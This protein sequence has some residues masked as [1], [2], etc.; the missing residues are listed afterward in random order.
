MK[1]IGFEL[2]DWERALFNKLIGELDL[3]LIGET[4]N[5]RIPRGILGCQCNSANISNLNIPK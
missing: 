5:T 2:E 4:L 3:L 1:V